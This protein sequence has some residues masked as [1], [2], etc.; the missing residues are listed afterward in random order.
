VKPVNKEKNMKRTKLCL[1]LAL[2]A[3]TAF[4]QGDNKSAPEPS[5]YRLDFVVKELDGGKVV[6]SRSYSM[7]ISSGGNITQST[8]IRNGSKVP[9]TA[10]NGTT[11]Y[12]DLGTNFDCRN[13]KMIG[14][15]LA[16]N[17]SAEVSSVAEPGGNPPVIRN[18]RWGGEVIV[19]LR[20][21]TTIFSSDDAMSKRQMQLELTATPI[22]PR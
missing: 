1:M 7:S 20:K 11:T 18:N 10:S 3:G 22:I 12:V 21:P 16:L 5:F 13:A 2:L 6:N 4:A 9:V 19:P 15:D 17:V 8:S 14:A